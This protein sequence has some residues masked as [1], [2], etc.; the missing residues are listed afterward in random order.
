MA[1]PAMLMP[2]TAERHRWMAENSCEKRPRQC[3]C[4]LIRGRYGEEFSGA[5]AIC[6]INGA[7][8]PRAARRTGRSNCRRRAR[9]QAREAAANP[10]RRAFRRAGKICREATIV[11]H[12]KST[13]RPDRSVCSSIVSYHC[14]IWSRRCLK[15][16][17][18]RKKGEKR[19]EFREKSH[20]LLGAPA[21][22]FG[23]CRP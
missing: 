19:R 11:P 15:N 9:R 7:D 12:G 16:R 10:D 18:N 17:R 2:T 13:S 22:F 20:R 6:Y 21:R 8:A 1:T 5:A 23:R 4:R 3:L 14:R